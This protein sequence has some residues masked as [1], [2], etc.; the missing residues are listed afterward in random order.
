MRA[1]Q[2]EQV[3]AYAL[4]DVPFDGFTDLV[5][6]RAAEKAGVPEDEMKEAFPHGPASLVAQFSEWADGEMAKAM[7]GANV[8]S[9]RQRVTRAMRARI[10]VL[11]PHKQ[12][13]RKAALFLARPQHAVLGVKL[14]AQTADAIWR[15]VGDTSTDFNYYSKRAIASGVFAATLVHWLNDNSDDSESTWTFLDERIANVMQFEKLK[16]QTKDVTRFIPDPVKLF[17][18]IRNAARPR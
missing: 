16:A 8:T 6:K 9:I 7:E 4:A 2:H 1:E 10:E 13:A 3:L 5:L 11:T 18:A 14:T 12:Q 17:A 15:A